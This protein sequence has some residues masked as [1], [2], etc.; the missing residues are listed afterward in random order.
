MPI[1]MI[2]KFIDQ[3]LLHGLEKVQHTHGVGSRRLRNAIG[4]YLNGH[5]AVKRVVL[6]TVKKAAAG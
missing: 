5:R 3:A 4:K 2:D 6:E 1:P